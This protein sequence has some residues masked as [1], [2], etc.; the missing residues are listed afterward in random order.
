MIKVLSIP[1]SGKALKQFIDFP[2]DLYKHDPYYV[3]ELFMAQK[4]LLNTAKHPFYIHGKIQ[5]FLAYQNEKIVGRIAA[6]INGNHN[7]FNKVNEGFFGF[8]DAINDV[9]VSR[10]LFKA[11]E[12]WLREQKVDC[13]IGPVNPSTNEPCGLLV[14]GFDSSPMV[15]MTYNAPY[16]M[17]LY[18]DYGL[19]KMVDLWAYALYAEDLGDKP[20]RLYDALINRLNAK[21][22]TIRSFDLKH[23]FKKELENFGKVY[24]AAWD[25]NMGFVPMTKEEFDFMGKDLKMVA[26]TDFC[27]AA[28]HN[29][30][31]IGIALCLPD[32]N[33]VLKKI[34]RG[35]LF[36]T[37]IFTFL[38]GRKKINALRIVALGVLEPYR[39]MGIEACF[40]AGIMKKGLAKGYKLGEASWM[41][42]HNDLMNRAIEH[43]HGVRYKNYRLYK[44]EL[45]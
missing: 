32:I 42:E 28:E 27:L 21:G 36:P 16:Y 39:K 5:L 43:M 6:I 17:D 45:Q 38:T 35:R 29:G 4:D 7:V 37:G 14:E 30:E 26:D 11:A 22:I 20:V 18:L 9:E 10:A 13:M 34:K 23:N 19:G 15:L 33:Q 41:L 44:K 25:R 3:P 31:V 40:Y 1:N 8:F 12:T 24:N 2:H